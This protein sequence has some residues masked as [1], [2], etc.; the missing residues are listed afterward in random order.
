MLV[1]L[2]LIL[3]GERANSHSLFVLFI[4]LV[5]AKVSVMS[6]LSC[7]L[8]W[9]KGLNLLNHPYVGSV[10]SLSCSSFLPLPWFQWCCT[11]NSM[12]TGLFMAFELQHFPFWVWVLGHPWAD[13]FRE[14][15]VMTQRWASV[16][17]V[18]HLKPWVCRGRKAACIPVCINQCRVTISWSV[19]WCSSAALWNSAVIWL[20]WQPQQHS[21]FS[22]PWPLL[23][24][25]Y[26]GVGQIRSSLDLCQTSA[27]TCSPATAVDMFYLTAC[28]HL[29][30]HDFSCYKSLQGLSPCVRAA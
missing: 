29:W 12:G 7:L 6:L 30:S 9:M 26:K 24:V 17:A 11:H 13:V 14:G 16:E 10:S 21:V 18:A 28:F 27:V 1:L 25:S 19:P 2:P 23:P 15:S 5:I 3:L 8:L 4:S 20:L 22:L